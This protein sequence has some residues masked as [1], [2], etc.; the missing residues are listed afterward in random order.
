MQVIKS[1]ALCGR[2]AIEKPLILSKKSFDVSTYSKGS[3]DEEWQKVCNA[4]QALVDMLNLELASSNPDKASSKDAREVISAY[5]QVAL[6]VALEEAIKEEIYEKNLPAPM[7]IEN[8]GHKISESIRMIPDSYIRTRYKDVENIIDQLEECLLGNTMFKINEDCIVIANDLNPAMLIKNL[9]K[10][11]GLILK[12]GADNSHTAILANSYDIPTLIGFD[13]DI[14]AFLVDEDVIIDAIKG[15]AYI[16]PDVTTL[17]NYRAMLNAFIEE[18]EALKEY[19]GK[20]AITKGGTRIKIYANIGSSMEAYETKRVGA[21]GIGLFR[22]EFLFLGREEAP[23]EEEQFNAYKEALEVMYPKEVVIRTC[24]VG[25][26]KMS[27]YIN[28]AREANPALG[29]RAVRIGFHNEKILR[30]QLRALYRASNYG[31]LSIN[32]PMIANEWEIDRIYEIIK[33]VKDELDREAIPYKYVRIGIMIETPAAALISQRL[34]KKVD[35]FSIGTN[36]LIQYTLACDRQND[37]VRKHL[38][39]HHEAVLS[40]IKMTIDNAHKNGIT[41]GVCGGLAQDL[42]LLDFFIENKVDELSVGQAQILRLKHSIC[43]K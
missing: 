20:S 16:S 21:D 29:L 33:E 30:T 23:G 35:F 25:A 24:D 14:S 7:A 1:R 37:E 31:N 26:D 12:V 2:I 15:E 9:G 43:L 8:G 34:A 5:V 3:A 10:I 17:T 4:R 28:V 13:E 42:D 11:K 32:F 40:L 39:V 41:V 22:S 27:S 6:D 19:I 18:D 36:D 38:D